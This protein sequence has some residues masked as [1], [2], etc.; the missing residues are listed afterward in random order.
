MRITLALRPL[1][2]AA[3]IFAT[4]AVA[5]AQQNNGVTKFVVAPQGN[6]ARYRVREQLAGIDFP[7][8]AI[9]RTTRIDGSIA[10]TAD[11]KVVTDE[12]RFTIDLE[13]LT[14]DQ[15]MRDNFLRR[16]TLQTAQFAS[17]VF[18]PKEIRGLTLPLRNGAQPLT[19]ELVG[20]LTVRGVTKEVVWEVT[21][22]LENNA[23]SG[24]AKTRFTFADF[25]LEKPRVRRVLSV[26]DDIALEYTFLLV[27]A[28][29]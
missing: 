19:F 25:Q 15:E 16:N 21:A 10:V 28:R 14:S 22:K 7:N 17:A 5:I 4:S 23:V 13:S 1:I 26:N 27:P 18:V 29:N 20:D 9:G 2:A 12:S 3:G 11:G 8:D 24:E 6:E